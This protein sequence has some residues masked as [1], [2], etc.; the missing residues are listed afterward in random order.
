M[1]PAIGILLF[2]AV[3]VAWAF[4]SPMETREQTKPLTPSDLNAMSE[5]DRMDQMDRW[6]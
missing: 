2:F 5:K 6:R 4:I 1:I 3:V